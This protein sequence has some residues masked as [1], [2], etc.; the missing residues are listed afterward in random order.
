MTTGTG[1]K[2]TAGVGKTARRASSTDD[3]AGVSVV[4]PHK[5]TI[6]VT[7]EFFDDLRAYATSRGMT[8]TELI[9]QGLAYERFLYENR[10]SQVMLVDED[11]E[12][13]RRE[14]EVLLPMSRH[15]PRATSPVPR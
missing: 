1:G 6:N 3:P 14:R 11:K 5:I 15:R 8:I 10:G 7:P 12:G 2:E 9:R 4:K 13:N